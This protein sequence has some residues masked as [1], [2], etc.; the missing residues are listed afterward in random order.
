M[1]HPNIPLADLLAYQKQTEALAQVAGR[2]GWD[3]ETVMPRGA[4]AQRG[5]EM[6]AME[7]VLHA[8]RTDPQLG[9]WLAACEGAEMSEA[10]A[11]KLRHIR[12]NYDRASKIPADL[13]AELARVTSVAQGQW[14]EARAADDFAA[15]APVLA[16]VVELRQQEGPGPGRGGRCL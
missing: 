7:A 5:E 8:R 4:A 15:F 1:T 6:A 2:L 3:Q 11:A 13:A 10:D 12:R 14:A 16:R 9:D